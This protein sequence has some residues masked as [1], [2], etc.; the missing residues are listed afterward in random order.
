MTTTSLPLEIHDVSLTDKEHQYLDQN[1]LNH[2]LLKLIPPKLG[3]EFAP[4]LLSFIMF[5]APELFSPTFLSSEAVDKLVKDDQRV[6]DA[7]TKAWE[8]KSFSGIRNIRELFPQAGCY[9]V[10]VL[11]YCRNIAK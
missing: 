6:L 5:G 7:L 3:A 8:K 1:V 4:S 2:P 10:H 11:S 9:K